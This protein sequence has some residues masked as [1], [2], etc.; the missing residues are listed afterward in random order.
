MVLSVGTRLG[1]YDVTALL[2]DGGIG[3][4]LAGARH[5]SSGSRSRCNAATRNG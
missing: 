4:V 2:G 1:H 5:P 3:Q